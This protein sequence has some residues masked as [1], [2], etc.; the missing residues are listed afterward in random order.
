ML[1]ACNVKL[2]TSKFNPENYSMSR[3][4]IAAI[5]LILS[6][7][8]TSS[9]Y[10]ASDYWR[11]LFIS[12]PDEHAYP[13]S[14]YAVGEA[15]YF[16]ATGY[17]QQQQRSNALEYYQRAVSQGNAD[18]AYRLAQYVPAQRKKW[19]RVAAQL[20]HPGAVTYLAQQVQTSDP[21]QAIRLLS[22]LA[23]T[24]QRN[25]L[26]A[27]LLFNHPYLISDTGI[28]WQA[29]APD[30]H[31]WQQRK[32]IAR[33]M[34][35]QGQFSVSANGGCETTLNMYLHGPEARSGA[36]Q[37][38]ASLAAHPFAELGLCFREMSW[39]DASA[40]SCVED[41]AGRTACHTAIEQNTTGPSIHVV[42]QGSANVRGSAMTIAEDASFEVLIHELGH[43]FSLADEYP[44]SADLAAAFCAG[45][46]RFSAS[47][48]IVTPRSKILWS[49]QELGAL[50]E[51]LPW[52]DYLERPIAVQ[53]V[54]QNKP[55]FYR[56]G[57]PGTVGVGLYPASTCEGTEYQAWRPVDALTFM[58]QHEVGSVPE[59]YLDLIQ[60]H[61]QSMAH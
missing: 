10:S 53:L 29:I 28:T 58:Q 37:W 48:I 3:P 36:Y 21:L 19:L 55:L 30:T 11:Q 33:Q 54:Q 8:L 22:G 25:E 61:Q 7:Q 27:G 47:N 13:A 9:Q 12:V 52:S 59:V 38:F 42:E 6:L 44:M 23:A 40:Y 56:L 43:L 15:S 1:F 14:F 50:L 51:K 41:D 60:A 24:E 49:Q 2:P 46:Y 32:Q 5:A 31:G 39:L 16:I 20:G 45:Q 57:S 4:F 18:A 34:A 35:T 26:L 17:W